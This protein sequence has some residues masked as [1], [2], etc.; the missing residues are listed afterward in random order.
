MSNPLLEQSVLPYGA[1]PFDRITPQHFLPAM[2]ATIAAAQAQIK[3]LSEFAG[4][5]T[6]ANTIEPLE[7][8]TA[9]VYDVAVCYSN[10]RS[11]HGDEQMHAL[12]K[13]IMPLLTKLE[14]DIYLDAALFARIKRVYQARETLALSSE[15]RTLLEKT[16]RAFRRNGA[17]LSDAQKSQLRAIDDELS[18]L[19]PKFSENVLKATNGFELWIDDAAGLAGLPSSAIEAARQAAREKNRPDSHLFTLAAPSYL[20]YMRYAEDRERRRQIWLAYSSRAVG[21][22]QGNEAQV[23]RIAS[24]R[25]ERARLL[26]YE[27]YAAFA[28]EE[29][30]AESPATV[31]SFLTRLLEKSRP[32][33]EREILELTQYMN[34]HGTPGPLQQ[35]DYAYWARRLKEERYA[36]NAE[37]LRP[38]F[39]LGQALAGAFLHAEKL[40]DLSFIKLQDVPV[41]ADGVEVYRVQERA[42]GQ[43][44]GLLYVDFFPRATKS[45]GAWCTRY[46]G[47]WRDDAE[48][49]RPHVSIVCNFTKPTPSSPSLLTFQEVET[50]FHEFGHALHC[51]LSRCQYRSLSCTSVYRDFVELPSQI[52]E[53]WLKEPESLGLVAKHYQSGASIPKT[54]VDKVIASENFHAAYL[55]MRQLRFALLD[56]AWYGQDPRAVEDVTAFEWQ[57]VAPTDLMPNQVGTNI[58]CAFEH[59]FDGGY[60]AGY[61]GYKWAEVL[62]ADAF[63]C[64]QEQGIFD[65]STADRFRKSILERGGSEHPMKLYREFRGRDP[66]PDALLRRDGLV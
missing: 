34:Q 37:E 16:F 49:H 26:G 46:R 59:I 63:A 36:F 28:L 9:A 7:R 17:M 39:E 21:G 30:M 6:F 52:M 11:A 29:R 58:S 43:Y 42:G 38:Y 23:K 5:D 47:Q 22:S 57:H 2:T 15:Q 64:F 24:L 50:L 14:S 25:F 8:A 32:V 13:S 62:D 40:F 19:G 65:R 20:A 4:Q 41:Y 53:N 44:M 12:A 48:D 3:A 1:V 54:M 55:M 35:W 27:S 45:G 31:R 61:Y 33:A 60:A 56:M 10:L 66:D 18:T 51:L